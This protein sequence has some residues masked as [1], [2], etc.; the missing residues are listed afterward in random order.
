MIEAFN[1]GPLLIPT[2]PLI[3]V[4][5]LF[6]AF[7][8]ASLLSLRFALE[9]SKVKRVFEYS[10]WIGVL[11]ARLS[12]VAMN[13]SAYRAAPWTVLYFWQPG[14]FYLGGLASG[15]CGALLLGLKFFPAKRRALFTVLGSSYLLAI[16]LYLSGLQSL[17]FFRQPGVSGVGSVVSDFRL[18]NLSGSSVQL[19]DLDGQGIVVNF[20]ATWCPP[21]RRE[22]PMLDDIQKI[23]H[24]RGISV[25]GIAI[26]EP[27][28]QVLSYVE[29][30]AVSYPIW[31]DASPSAV[32]FDRTQDIFSRFGGI[33]FPTTLFIDRNGVIHTIYVGELSRGF[34]Q[35]QI[36]QLL[37][38]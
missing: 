5:S 30:V 21:C 35:S 15:I 23:Y 16:L 20:W 26:G 3:L 4:L 32:G 6:F 24:A 34:L 18:R 17:E 1:L 22:M 10:A 7:W 12:F 36:D 13:W 37:D 25:V 8:F 2:R 14:Y 11:G 33:G 9:K 19:S 31:V 27:A 38:S 28:D 29:S